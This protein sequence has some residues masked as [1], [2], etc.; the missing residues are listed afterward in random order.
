MPSIYD[1]VTAPEIAAYW[2]ENVQY[3]QPYFGESKFPNK[4]KLGLDLA[5]IKGARKAPV[6]LSL[7]AFDADVLPL[8]R[9][10]VSRLSTEM[11]F[12]KNE[13]RIDERTRQNLNI[14]LQ[15]GNAAVNTVVGQIFDDEANLMR[16]AAL[17]REMLRM[18]LL[19][20]GVIS[21]SDNGQSFSYDF[22]L[23]SSH[24]VTP[25]TKW[26][27][28]ATADPIAD[29][30]TWRQIIENEKGTSPNEILLNSATLAKMAKVDAVKNGV[31]ANTKA[32]STP[33]KAQVV[34]F[35]EEQLGVTV[36][37]YDKGYTK[38]GTFK[39]FVPDGTVVLMPDTDLGSTWFGTT[40][41]ESD[42]MGGN[43][44]AQVRLVDTGV[45]I[46]TWKEKDPVNVRTK[47]SQVVLP[48]FELADEVIIAS[49]LT[50]S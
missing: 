42:L 32:T 15:A 18:Q 23:P 44:D 1:I 26:D 2:N 35:I 7:S 20:T 43:T 22:G 47:G 3:E 49:V 19:T 13:Y 50:A 38:D 6:S 5:W 34:A 33:T 28:T 25:T 39:K 29:L 9:G 27:V 10:E 36:Y 21:L 16:N 8:K 45:A 46:T 30:D 12:F 17:T 31:F 4:K 37:V 48:S 41:E 24:K 11:P 40:P 14:L